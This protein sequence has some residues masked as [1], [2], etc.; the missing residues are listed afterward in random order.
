MESTTID[1]E[2]EDKSRVLLPSYCDHQTACLYRKILECNV[3]F[4]NR[5]CYEDFYEIKDEEHTKKSWF[6]IELPSFSRNL[7][8][9]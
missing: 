3:N 9:K 2:I 6:F 4:G 7:N 1:T 5:Q 8:K